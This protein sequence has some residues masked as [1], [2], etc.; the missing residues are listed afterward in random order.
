MGAPDPDAIQTV[1]EDEGRWFV[2]YSHRCGPSRFWPFE[3]SVGGN[4]RRN[5]ERRA[6]SIMK[7]VIRDG[8]VC[9]YCGD[10]IGFHKRADAQYCR[11]RCKRAAARQRRK[12][13][14]LDG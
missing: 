9:A 4:E 2:W 8:W 10:E 7:R 12:A 1:F 6:V 11:E 3:S 14:A 13:K 5:R